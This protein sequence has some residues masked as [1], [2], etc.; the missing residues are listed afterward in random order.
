MEKSA[1]IQVG[2]FGKSVIVRKF[3]VSGCGFVD[4]SEETAGEEI[5]QDARRVTLKSVLN[6][7]KIFISGSRIQPVSGRENVL[8]LV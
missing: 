5:S 3:Q 1:E 2:K 8:F 6:W 7:I 4:C